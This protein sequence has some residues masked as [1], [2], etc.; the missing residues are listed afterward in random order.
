[1]ATRNTAIND[2]TKLAKAVAER[3]LQTGSADNNAEMLSLIAT[4]TEQIKRR[5]GNNSQLN[6]LVATIEA[7]LHAPGES[8]EGSGDD[9]D[10]KD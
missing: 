8:V 2:I 7:S 3:D 5:S 9:A 4:V 1:M 6:D 10:R